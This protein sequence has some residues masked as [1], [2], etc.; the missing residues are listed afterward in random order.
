MP[1][2]TRLRWRGSGSAEFS[3]A[4]RGRLEVLADDREVGRVVEVGELL[5]SS[6]VPG[7]LGGDALGFS[8]EGTKMST[9]TQ[10]LFDAATPF[11]VLFQG[12]VNDYTLIVNAV[13]PAPMDVTIEG[14]VNCASEK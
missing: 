10:P 9:D 4:R 1:S 8:I 6:S 11:V 14:Q 7:D 3:A 5:P 12:P 2:A 13:E